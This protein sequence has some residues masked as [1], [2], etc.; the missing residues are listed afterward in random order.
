MAVTVNTYP[1]AVVPAGNPVLVQLESDNQFSAAGVACRR[2]INLTGTT[3]A[4]DTIVFT[5][6]DNELTFTFKATPDDSGLQLTAGGTVATLVSELGANYLLSNAFMIYAVQNAVVCVARATGSDYDLDIDISDCAAFAAGVIDTDPVDATE[7]ANF[8]LFL[9]VYKSVNGTKLGEDLQTPDLT[10]KS[11]FNIAD[12]LLDEISPSVTYPLTAATKKTS[13]VLTYV[14]RYAER[15]GTI[16][17]VRQLTT[18]DP[19]Y[20]IAAR[21]P[22]WKESEWL[23][24]SDSWW[25]RLQYE[26]FFLSWSPDRRVTRVQPER[27]YF[28]VW[29]ALT[30]AQLDVIAT[31]YFT[32]GTTQEGTKTIASAS[33]YEIYEIPCGYAELGLGTYET[34]GKVCD[35]YTVHVEV[36][37]NGLVVSET[38]RF[39]LEDTS[40]YDRYFVFRNSLGGYDTIRATGEKNSEVKISAETGI[41][42]DASEFTAGARERLKIVSESQDIH[43][44]DLGYTDD[45]EEAMWR[46]ELLISEDVYELVNSALVPI[47]ITTDSIAKYSDFAPLYSAPIEYTYA[48][49]SNAFMAEAVEAFTVGDYSDDFAPDFEN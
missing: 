14:M 47:V 32:D 40:D 11:T 25:T 45:Y 2:S 7:Q 8:G 43:T 1:P 21:V 48:H 13:M 4:D 28:F 18:S 23:Q 30:T 24:S 12:Y 37:S 44:V 16:A 36:H 9:S 17:A 46:T 27:L 38:K 22:G 35:Y 29:N 31:M 3:A 49:Q 10:G 33:Q 26:K 42:N 5:W 39:N 34:G 6:G 20:A 41:Y 19:F 15:Y